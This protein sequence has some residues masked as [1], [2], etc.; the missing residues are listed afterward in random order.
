[1]FTEFF[2]GE[3]EKQSNGGSGKTLENK[4][5]PS[6]SN[7]NNKPPSGSNNKDKPPPPGWGYR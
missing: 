4:D 2:E 7:N 1:M 5:K 6:V 3:K